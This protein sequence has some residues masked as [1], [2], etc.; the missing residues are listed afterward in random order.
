MNWAQVTPN[1]LPWVNI[2]VLLIKELD[3]SIMLT[4][5]KDH[6]YALVPRILITQC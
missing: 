6:L 5:A 4:N 2:E 3:V 1:G